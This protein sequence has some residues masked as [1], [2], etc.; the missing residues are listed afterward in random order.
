[1]ID[2]Q[3]VRPEGVRLPSL[4]VSDALRATFSLYHRHFWT[5]VLVTSLLAIPTILVEPLSELIVVA[6]WPSDP[7]DPTAVTTPLDRVRGVGR[8]AAAFLIAMPLSTAVWALAGGAIIVLAATR[9]SGSHIGVGAAYSRAFGQFG[10]L[11]LVGLMLTVGVLALAFTCLGVLALPYVLPALELT[12][13]AVLLERRRPLSAIRRSWRLAKGQRW[14][15]LLCQLTIVAIGWLLISGPV[16]LLHWLLGVNHD[17]PVLAVGGG[18]NVDSLTWTV[19]IID[20]LIYIVGATFLWPLYYIQ[21]TILYLDL[22]AREAPY[23]LSTRRSDE[24]P[25][26]PN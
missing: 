3:P 14:R 18:A 1:V 6:A 17:S 22:R 25:P 7:Q 12:D 26:Q 4:A 2:E 15:I 13:Q 24:V 11:F 21:A 8:A 10:S 19:W 9:R 23:R 16:Y 5:F 20:Q